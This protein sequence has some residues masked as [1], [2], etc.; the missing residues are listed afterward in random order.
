MTP[1]R[2]QIEY[3]KSLLASSG[4]SEIFQA[5]EDKYTD[6]WK[7]SSHTDTA[8]REDAYYMV[9]ALNDLRVELATIAK[10]DEIRLYNSRLAKQNQLR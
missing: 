4:I 7:G 3:A 2:E 1:S 6:A 8:S 10:S 9:R 5:L